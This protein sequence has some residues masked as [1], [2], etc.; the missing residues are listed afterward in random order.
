[1]NALLET[2]APLFD[3]VPILRA[4]RIRI[5][6]RVR[7][8]G[9]PAVLVGVATIVLAAG[10]ARTAERAVPALTGTLGEG[11]RLWALWRGRPSLRP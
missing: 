11:R 7:L 1:M 3:P 10:V 8:Q 6:N 5:G 9:V 2:L 4:S